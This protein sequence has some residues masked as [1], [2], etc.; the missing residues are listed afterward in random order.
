MKKSIILILISC[1]FFN[2]TSKVEEI[3]SYQYKGAWYWVLQHKPDAT[4]ADVKE[5]VNRWANPNQTSYFFVYPNT[6]NLNDFK[7]KD[8]TFLYFKD[9]IINNA[10]AYGYYKMVNDAV[11]YEDAVWLMSVD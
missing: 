9:L 1:L 3:T 10:P 5:F 2:C 8:I 4:E 6:I 7:R 11:I